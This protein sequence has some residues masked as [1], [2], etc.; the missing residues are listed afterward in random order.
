MTST[1]DSWQTEWEKTLAAGRK[2]GQVIVQVIAPSPA[3]SQFISKTFKE[4][5]GINVDLSGLPS[6]IAQEKFQRERKS[7]IFNLDINLSSMGTSFLFYEKIE[8]P[9]VLDNQF[10]LPEVKDSNVW[11][12]GSIFLDKGHKSAGGFA[13]VNCMLFINSQLVRQGEVRSLDDILDPKWKGKIIIND[14][15]ISG[16]GNAALRT[17]MMFKGEDYLKKLVEQNPVIT[18]DARIQTEWVARGKYAVSIGPSFG[19]IKDFIATG[20]PLAYVLP[21][22]GAFL[23]NSPGVV[24]LPTNAPHPNAAKIFINWILTREAQTQFAIAQDTASRRLD[25]SAEHLALERRPRLD[26]RYIKDN[27]EAFL[28][29]NEELTNRIKEIFK[30]VM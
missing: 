6:S 13:G 11:M 16:T 21:Q 12:D 7:G 14:P 17:I 28:S 24:L 19:I 4:K 20:A 10:I 8:F 26:V 18:R 22:E 25:V 5:F 23:S 9:E 2:E 3:T 15:S 29:R 30:P 27:D 1:Q